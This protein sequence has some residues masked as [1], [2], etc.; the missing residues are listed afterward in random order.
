MNADEMKGVQA[1][2]RNA[3]TIP[4]KPGQPSR[5]DFEYALSGIEDLELH[6]LYRAMG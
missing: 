4:M 2:E 5:I 3:K 1:L 6:H